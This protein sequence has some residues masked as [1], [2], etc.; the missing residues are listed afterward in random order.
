MIKKWVLSLGGQGFKAL[1]AHW[2]GLFLL[3]WNAYSYSG[4]RVSLRD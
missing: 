1:D 2:S 3:D 4:F